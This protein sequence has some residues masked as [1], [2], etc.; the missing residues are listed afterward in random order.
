MKAIFDKWVTSYDSNET[1]LREFHALYL[2]SRL[3]LTT[4]MSNKFL[5]L[6][7]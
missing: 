1:A 4:D 2:L 7:L 5:V 3:I 6:R